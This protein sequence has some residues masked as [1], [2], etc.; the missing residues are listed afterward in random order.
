MRRSN[1]DEKRDVFVILIILMAFVLVA[2]GNENIPYE[3]SQVDVTIL[4]ETIP[5]E[6]KIC[7][8]GDL[9]L[10]DCQGNT[11][12]YIAYEDG[13]FTR[14]YGGGYLDTAATYYAEGMF[15]RNDIAEKN[16]VIRKN[17]KLVVFCDSDYTLS[18]QPVKWET[19]AIAS[20]YLDGTKVYMRAIKDAYGVDFFMYCEG[21]TTGWDVTHVDGISVEEYPF[22]IV[23]EGN[24]A[25]AGLPKGETIKFGVVRG[26][27]LKE[28]SYPIN[29]T[30]YRCDVSRNVAMASEEEHWLYPTPTS[31]GYAI[32]EI[33]DGFHNI[34]IPTGRYVMELRMGKSYI[35]YL[36]DWENS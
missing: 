17:D 20:Q 31:S 13:S 33:Y 10:E 26:T 7:T 9:A 18:L 15:L 6:T 27:T 2:C 22:E 14:Y 16:P 4:E 29:A 36:L 34:E 25:G 23:G 32:I 12:I 28:Q 30:Y 8:I 35:A 3:T 19:G 11:G 24:S 5:T 1:L 21:D